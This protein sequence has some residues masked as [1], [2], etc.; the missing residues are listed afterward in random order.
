[1]SSKKSTLVRRLALLSLAAGAL[2]GVWQF[3]PGDSPVLEAV[4]PAAAAGL[5]AS[6]LYLPL[7]RKPAVPTVFGMDMGAVTA[8]RGLGELAQARNYWL[9][10]GNLVWADVEPNQGE[11][12]WSALAELEVEMINAA[13]QGM[14][15]IVIVHGAPDWAR[16]IP[17]YSCGPIRPDALGAFASFM[18]DLAARYRAQPYK[19]KYWEIWNEPDATPN[20]VAEESGFGC[21]GDVSDPYYG[22]RAFGEMLKVAT[23]LVKAANPQAQVIIGGLLLDCDPNNPPPSKDCTQSRFLEGILTAGGGPYFDGL[24]FH[25]YDYYMYELGVYSNANW[26]SASDT[27]G[28]VAR[29]KAQYLRNLLTSYGAG[30]KFLMNTEAAL[31]CSNEEN[32]PLCDTDFE[33]TKAYYVS[34]SYALAIAEGFAANVWYSLYGWR[35]SGLFYTP[36]EPRPAFTAFAFARKMIGSAAYVRLIT[37]YPGVDGYEF[38]RDGKTIWLL[39]S[40]DGSPHP[41]ALPSAP[42][43]GYDVFGNPYAVPGA[44]LD[45]TMAPVY[46]VW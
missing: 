10:R 7:I 40:A 45:A 41:V 2:L 39:W 46:L 21:W 13:H 27:T 28:P 29:A 24:S 33:Q 18:Y 3:A 16:A 30:G 15:L 8:Q 26:N 37:E 19:V 35:N 14:P 4:R 12:N 22:G 5:D 42:Q 1:M 36:T 9:R 20:P 25:A 23:P 38:V 31:L 11:R 6:T 44:S 43:A 17:G 34:Q 32:S